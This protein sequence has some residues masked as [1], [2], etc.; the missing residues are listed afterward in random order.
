MIDTTETTNVLNSL[1]GALENHAKEAL[2]NLS[3][4]SEEAAQKGGLVLNAMADVGEKLVEG[5]IDAVS[6]RLAIDNYLLALELYGTKLTNQAQVE[7]YQ[8]GKKILHVVVDLGLAA[9]GMGLNAAVPGLGNLL[10]GL[11][12]RPV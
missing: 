6:A 4:A 11:T 10:S 5:R 1:K 8:R 9:L 3:K 12:V 7:A 2:E